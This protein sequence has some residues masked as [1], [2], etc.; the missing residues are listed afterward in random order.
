LETGARRKKR[1]E[2]DHQPRTISFQTG[3]KRVEV[4]A[5]ISRAD[6][7]AITDRVHQAETEALNQTR[8]K[9]AAELKQIRNNVESVRWPLRDPR[10]TTRQMRR[11]LNDAY[12]LLGKVQ[13]GLA[14]STK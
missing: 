6:E 11:D 5:R 1:L 3:P 12:V 13:K 2:R 10:I 7:S 9:L 14:N 4:E 8:S